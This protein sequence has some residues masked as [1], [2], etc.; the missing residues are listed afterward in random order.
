M[1]MLPA[2]NTPSATIL[3]RAGALAA[4]AAAHDAQGEIGDHEQAEDP[5]REPHVD[6]HVAVQDVAEL[7]ADDGLQLVAVEIV[8]RALR[9]RDRGFV[10]RMT[11]RE[12]VDA[13]LFGQHEDLRLA[14]A[15]RDG[16]F[17]DDVEQA[18]ALEIA[19]PCAVTATPPSERAT[20]APPA[21]SC[22]LLCHEAI[23]MIPSTMIVSPN[24]DFGVIP[25]RVE[26]VTD[27]SHR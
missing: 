19:R 12:G 26:R 1:P 21:R 11:G 16:H 17:L 8:E 18:L 14:D 22:E 20:T 24:D 5:R 23:S 27:Q 10:G 13:L 15:R 4:A 7:V 9:H 2:M 25:Q 3:M 6:L